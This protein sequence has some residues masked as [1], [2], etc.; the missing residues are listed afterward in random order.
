[1]TRRTHR[2]RGAA[3][4]LIIAK[5]LMRHA[6]LNNPAVLVALNR[7]VASL[8]L[9]ARV[10]T[11]QLTDTE[12]LI[13]FEKAIH[14]F[15]RKLHTE[16]NQRW[17]KQNIDQT[18]LS[19][20]T[21][22]QNALNNPLSIASILMVDAAVAIQSAIRDETYQ[23]EQQYMQ[24]TQNNEQDT[25]NNEQ[26]SQQASVTPDSNEA[27]K[28]ALL[29]GAVTLFDEKGADAA[30]GQIESAFFKET[31]IKTEFHIEEPQEEVSSILQHVLKPEFKDFQNDDKDKG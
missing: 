17:A 25:Q 10:A 22:M 9:P 19:V 14:S 2:F 29:V 3:H 13:A 18:D 6:I 20:P 1:M 5:A 11:G 4:D 16:L 31:G 26:A 21:N 23:N 27:E 30:K 15:A 24:D 28:A 7:Y 12:A 8:C